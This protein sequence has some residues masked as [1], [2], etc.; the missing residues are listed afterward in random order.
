MSYVAEGRV[1]KKGEVQR[2]ETGFYKQELR[3]TT[4]S[5]YPTVLPLIF[6]KEK[7]ELIKDVNVGDNVRVNFDIRSRVVNDKVFL[8]LS[9]WKIQVLV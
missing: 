6:F 3:I 2:W 8:D 4:N 5:E 7:G 1:T 9:G